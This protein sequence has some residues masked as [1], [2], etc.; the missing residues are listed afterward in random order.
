MVLDYKTY[1]VLQAFGILVH[2]VFHSLN[3]RLSMVFS[4]SELL[5]YDVHL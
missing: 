5:K 1:I 2:W 3:C 4:N